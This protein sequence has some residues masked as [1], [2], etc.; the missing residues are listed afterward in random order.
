MTARD[1]SLLAERLSALED[2]LDD[3]DWGDVLERASSSR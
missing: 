2:P 3:S 1:D